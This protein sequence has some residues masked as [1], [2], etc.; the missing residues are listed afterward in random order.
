MIFLVP[1]GKATSKRPQVGMQPELS[2]MLVNDRPR[3]SSFSIGK[4]LSLEN[5][6]VVG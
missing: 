5:V 6:K 2:Q 3:D 4:R 1:T